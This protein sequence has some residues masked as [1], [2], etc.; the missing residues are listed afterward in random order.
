MNAAA[1]GPDTLLPRPPGGM[2]PGA[3]L[4]LL[5]HGVLLLAL[6]GVMDWRVQRPSP[7]TAELW[8]SVPQVAAPPPPP[9]APEP[10]PAP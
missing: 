10:A 8:A 7:V 2:A 6:T 1:L 9:P 3:L 5:V 4:A